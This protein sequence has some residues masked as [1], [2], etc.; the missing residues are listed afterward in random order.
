M[1]VPSVSLFRSSNTHLA[2]LRAKID[3]CTIALV[4]PA[5]LLLNL[6]LASFR[7]LPFEGNR[8]FFLVT[9]Y[10]PDTSELSSRTSRDN[11]AHSDCR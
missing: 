6:S 3:L 9:F 1:S 10:D 4:H 7:R 8:P 5:R 2:N 11:S